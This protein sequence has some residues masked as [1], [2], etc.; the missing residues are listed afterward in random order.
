MT[1]RHIKPNS[2]FCSIEGCDGLHEAKGYCRNHYRQFK[3]HGDPLHRTDWAK[4]I[5]PKRRAEGICAVDGCCDTIERSDM[6]NLHYMRNWRTG[7]P[8]TRK[9][10]QLRFL[11]SVVRNPTNDCVI[12]PFAKRSNGYGSY[13]HEGKTVSAHRIALMMLTKENPKGKL[14]A[15][16][17]CHNRL[18]INPHPEHGMYWGDKASNARDQIRDGTSLCGE[19]SHKAI[20]TDVEA[21]EVLNMKAQG[22]TT[23][24][25]LALFPQTSLAQIQAIIAGRTYKHLQSE[26]S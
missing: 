15:H 5:R 24:E 9:E 4:G 23:K 17:P 3:A 20:L 11:E 16:G 25:I 22:M 19:K 14:A 10:Q 26:S 21:V 13:C 12:W 6:C 2:R 7:S 8:Y 18:C 1:K